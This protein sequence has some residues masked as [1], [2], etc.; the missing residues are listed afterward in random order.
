[1]IH[2]AFR[3]LRRDFLTSGLNVLGSGVLIFAF[4]LLISL[5]RT[6]TSFGLETDIAQNLVVLRGNSLSPE[7][8]FIPPTTAGEVRGILGDRQRQIEPII[9]RIMRVE[10]L[11]IQLRGVAREAWAQ[12]FRLQLIDGQWPSAPNEIVVDQV[13]GENVGWRPGDAIKV[14]GSSLKITG[15]VEGRGS[16]TLTVWMDYPAAARL[17]GSDK[18]AQFIVANLAPG[19]DPLEAKTDMENGLTELGDYDVYFEEA[20]LREYGT[21]LNDL[22]ALTSLLTGIAMAA[23]TLSS[24]N[25]AWLAAD[26]RRQSLGLMRALGFTRMAVSRYLLL[27]AISIALLSYVLALIAAR[28]YID[29]EIGGHLLRMG[30]VQLSMVLDLPMAGLGLV[31]ACG[32]TLLGSWI[33]TRSISKYAPASLLGRGSGAHEL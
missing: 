26:E 10:D 13:L 12:T 20:I 22:G 33:S 3:D 8:S 21:I 27:R 24:H 29:L 15:T 2:L 16:K 28:L 30:G 23:V 14:Y 25:M 18:G 32:S 4:L 6:L 5:A 11:T 31:L 7:Q 1:M 17:F 19:V 9:F